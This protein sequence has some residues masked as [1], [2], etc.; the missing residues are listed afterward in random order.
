MQLSKQ[1][2]FDFVV[3]VFRWF[4]AFYMVNYGWAKLFGAQFGLAN[5]QILDTPV[6]DVNTFYLA[7]HLFSLSKVFNV[8]VG[9]S[10]I[11]G[12][13]LI[14]VNP[15]ALIG[16]LVLL[17]ILVQIFLIDIAFTTSQ[18]GYALPLRLAAMIFCDLIGS[19]I[20]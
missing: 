12:A 8:V 6:K 18:F 11:L 7:W 5:T 10:Q 17:P 4:L 1:K 14:V 16:A 19:V 3:L 15:T 20:L 9:L 13:V 2:V